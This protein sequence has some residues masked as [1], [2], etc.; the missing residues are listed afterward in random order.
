MSDRTRPTSRTGLP[1]AE[2]RLRSRLAQ[3][4]HSQ[5]LLRGTLL[6]RRRGCGKA[7]CKCARGQLHESLY[8]VVSEQGRQRQ[9]FIPKEWEPLV[10]RW[11]ANHHDARELLEEI[12]RI[13]WEKVRRRK[14]SPFYDAC[15][16]MVAS[17]WAGNHRWRRCAMPGSGRRS[18]PA[19]SCG[20]RP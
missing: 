9:L 14:N 17:V 3:L 6:V 13:Y 18:T 4:V 16:P 5:G 20:R 8:L 1:P 11:V 10:R 19:S 15:W 7:G 12:S 2:R